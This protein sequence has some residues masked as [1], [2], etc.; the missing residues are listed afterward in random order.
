VPLEPLPI[1]LEA[2]PFGFLPEHVKPVGIGKNGE[3]DIRRCTRPPPHRHGYRPDH[4]VRDPSRLEEVDKDEQNLP[5]LIRIR[6][7]AH[8]LRL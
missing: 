2:M 5:E 6:Q 1:N 4:H 8:R 3:I 7:D